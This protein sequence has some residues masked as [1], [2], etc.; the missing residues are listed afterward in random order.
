[1]PRSICTAGRTWNLSG[2][3]SAIR[4]NA[5]AP[6]LIKT[7]FAKALWQD[8]QVERA[9]ASANPLRRLG[10]VEDIAGVVLMPASAAGGYTNGQTIVVDGGTMIAG[11][12]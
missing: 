3:P 1:M 5:I 8:P 12:H 11:P 2:A 6:G 9:K 10:T 4:V 7:D